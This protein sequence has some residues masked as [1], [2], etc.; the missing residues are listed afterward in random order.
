VNRTTVRGRYRRAF[1]IVVR[2]IVIVGGVVLL[3]QSHA[4]AQSSALAWDED[5]ASTVSGFAVTVDGVRTDYGSTPVSSSGSCACSIALPFTSGRH[6]VVVSAY[7]SVGESASAPL[8]VGPTA[9]AGGPYSVQ[10][11]TALTVSAANSTDNIGTITSYVWNWGDG[12]PN[13]TATS[14]TTTHTYV[15]AGTFTLTVTVSDDFS[16]SDSATTTANVATVAQPPGVPTSPSPADGA[17]GVSTTPT[18]AWTSN[19][20]TSYDVKF[21][22]ANPP[23]QV[24]SGQAAAAYAPGTLTAGATYYWQIVGQSAGGTATGPVWSFT[25]AVAPPGAPDSP[26]PADGATAVS[27]T[28][29]LTWSASGA[30]SYDVQFGATN[31]PPQV[32]SGQTTN[33]YTPAALTNGTPYYW[34]V[35]ARN[36]GG[37]T[38]GPVWTF[39]TIAAAPA[40]P[41]SPNPPDGAS[42]VAMLPT[43]TWTATGAMSYDV[44]FGTTNPPP[45]VATGLTL[46]VFVPAG[47][48]ISTTYY[49][50]VVARNTTAT[51]TGPVW[52]FTTIGAVLGAPTSPNPAAGATNISS[53]P[54]LSWTAS[55]ATSYDVMFGTTNPP[56]RVVSGQTSTSYAPGTLRA[57]TTYFWQVTAQDSGGT[58]GPVWSFTTAPSSAAGDI[59]I[60]ASDV[61]PDAVHGAWTLASD[62]SAANGVLL[63]TP[64]N[65]WNTASAPLVAPSHYIDVTFTAVPGTPYTLWLRL[66]ALNDYKRND[67]VWVQFSDA[68]VNGSAIYPLDSSSGL[69]VNLATDTTGKSLNGWG[70]S[71]AAF[72]LTQPAMLTFSSATTHTLRIQIREDGGQFD[73][74]VLSSATYLT[75]P[76]GP[77]T[78]DSTIIPK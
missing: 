22:T 35:V 9:N 55:G 78:N 52:S 44:Q 15:A 17:T 33:A 31:P 73:Q 20:A 37:N 47:L 65:G 7:N 29:T 25:T 77:P 3:H 36:G 13:T 18:L 41:T 54:M 39:T 34:R 19:G 11:G 63:M 75:T 30:T 21:G 72:W 16:A 40:T 14:V 42:G 67:S 60:Y 28:P 26:N 12:S 51:T 70:W 2:H 68:L 8:V 5:P 71:N 62:P 58:A 69:I 27:T 1:A 24:A 23:P 50:R 6:I 76:P 38:A 48:T 61:P 59:V 4:V 74:I 49:W 10:A 53:T 46:P 56:P 32:I 66:R 64:D 45:Q 43:L 57:A